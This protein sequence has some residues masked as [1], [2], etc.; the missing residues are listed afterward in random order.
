MWGR[1]GGRQREVS[2]PAVTGNGVQGRACPVLSLGKLLPGGW[3]NNV[4]VWP[5]RGSPNSRL[6]LQNCPVG[7]SKRF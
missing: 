5:P 7:D 1:A 6:S 2:A 4:G 3:A